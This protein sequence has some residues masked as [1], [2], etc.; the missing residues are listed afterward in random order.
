MDRDWCIGS[1]EFRAELLAQVTRRIGPNH[2]GQER[3]ESAEHKAARIIAEEVKQI[4]LDLVQL[5]LRPGCSGAKLRVARRLRRETTMSLRW[6]AQQLGFG[7]WKYLSN[8]LAQA[9]Q[10]DPNQPGLGL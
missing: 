3:R 8:L 5:Q 9:P 2:F 10:D 1:A 6:I 7:S 4:G